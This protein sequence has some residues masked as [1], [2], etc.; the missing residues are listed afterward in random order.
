[1]PM[2]GCGEQG[3]PGRFIDNQGRDWTADVE[4]WDHH[5]QVGSYVDTLMIC[6]H[7]DPGRHLRS[8]VESYS[9]VNWP[10]R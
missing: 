7:L 1:M 8:V 3:L 9:G 5:R 2:I 10:S 6:F 4:W